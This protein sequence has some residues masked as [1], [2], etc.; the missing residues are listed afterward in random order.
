MRNHLEGGIGEPCIFYEL[1]NF[2]INK[3]WYYS[4]KKIMVGSKI[5]D[6]CVQAFVIRT[7]KI[8]YGIT[9]QSHTRDDLIGKPA[10]NQ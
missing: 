10:V 9:L 6:T 7:N 8:L 1:A 3:G 2:Y 5:Q 4:G